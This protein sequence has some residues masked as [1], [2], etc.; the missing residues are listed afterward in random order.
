MS[1]AVSANAPAGV[2]VDRD[3]TTLVVVCIVLAAL[4]GALILYVCVKKYVQ[5][6]KDRAM[7]RL[8]GSVEGPSSFYE[9]A[10]TRQQSENLVYNSEEL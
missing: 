7:R 6:R 10:Q 8:G 1:L 3:F 5:R 4:L 9:Y 2:S